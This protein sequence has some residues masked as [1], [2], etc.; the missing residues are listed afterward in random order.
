[1]TV[2]RE[3]TEEMRCSRLELKQMQTQPPTRCLV[4]GSPYILAMTEA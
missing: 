3:R 1:M 4:M 2:V